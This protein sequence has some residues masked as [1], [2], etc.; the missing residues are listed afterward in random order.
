M[1]KHSKYYT[2]L[3]IFTIKL[4]KGTK[5][6]PIIKYPNLKIDIKILYYFANTVFTNDNENRAISFYKINFIL[7]HC[8]LPL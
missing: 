2:I 8:D 7:I 4:K 1:K 6:V 3:R 5:S